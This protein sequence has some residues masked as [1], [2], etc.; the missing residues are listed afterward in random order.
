MFFKLEDQPKKRI[1]ENSI[2]QV[3]AYGE[4]LMDV[5]M[6]FDKKVPA[7]TTVPLH[8]HPHLQVT[9][10]VKGSFTFV[11]QYPEGEK[12]ATLKQGDSLFVPSN[13]LHGCIPLE[14]GSQFLDSFT[15]IR[16]E[17]L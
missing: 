12:R 17:F 3:L 4:G 1:D 14:D 8:Q 7:D 16:Q 9:Y 6:T 11:I 2:R 13:L 5:L 10:I 15:P